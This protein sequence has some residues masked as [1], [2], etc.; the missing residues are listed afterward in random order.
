MPN[1]IIGR[2]ESS[3]EKNKCNDAAKDAFTYSS[4]VL[5]PRRVLRSRQERRNLHKPLKKWRARR[6]S[7][8]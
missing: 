5:R 6:D 7:N 3:N 1:S 4:A 2:N 8:S